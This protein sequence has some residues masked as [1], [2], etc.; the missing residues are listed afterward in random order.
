MD[1]PIRF[2]IFSPVRELEPV[3]AK[4]SLKYRN[5]CHDVVIQTH[6]SEILDPCEQSEKD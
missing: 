6:F 5:E 1:I 2:K 3:Q 4:L